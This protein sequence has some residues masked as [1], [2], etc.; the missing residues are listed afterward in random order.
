MPSYH[1]CFRTPNNIAHLS[2]QRDL[3]DLRQALIAAHQV[4]RM[5]LHKHVRRAPSALHGS[6]DI[7]DEDRQP[8]AR[9]LLA[10]LARQ[11][12]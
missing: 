12:S 6:L 2:E 9:I 3:P 10:D 5:L 8:V 4:G 11:I 1:F 7:E